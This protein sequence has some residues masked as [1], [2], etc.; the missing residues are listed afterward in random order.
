VVLAVLISSCCPAPS[1]ALASPTAFEATMIEQHEHVWVA[2]STDGTQ[3]RFPGEGPAPLGSRL[4][5]EGVID[6]DGNVSLSRVSV[7]S[8]S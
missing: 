2:E 7:M 8:G 6:A 3:Y 4:Y 5:L 1:V